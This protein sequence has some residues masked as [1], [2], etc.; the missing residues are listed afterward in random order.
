MD[1]VCAY[2]DKTQAAV[3]VCVSVCVRVSVCVCVSSSFIYAVC[4][5]AFCGQQFEQKLL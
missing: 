3:C 1:T 5:A 2:I 4:T